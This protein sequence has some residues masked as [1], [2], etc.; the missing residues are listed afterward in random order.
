[1]TT[2]E[3]PQGLAALADTITRLT[4]GQVAEYVRLNPSQAD[5]VEAAIEHARGRSAAWAAHNHTPT[6]WAT[7]GELAKALDPSTVQTPALQL[8]DDVLVDVEAGRCPRTIISMPPQEGKTMRATIRGATW[9]LRRNMDLRMGIVSYEKD[10]AVRISY[11]IRNDITTFDG[12]DG[13]ID[14]GMRL[15]TDSKAAGWWNLAGHDGGV[16]AV[17]IGGGLTSRPLD[18]LW[19][20]DPVKDYRAVDS[21]VQSETAWN[22]WQ[23]VARPRLAPGAPVVLILTRWHELDLA[24][25]LLA[26]QASDEAAGLVNFDRWRVINIPAQADFDPNK[27]ESDILGRE[28]GEFMVSARGRTQEQWEATKAATAPRIWSALYQGK[29]TPDSGDVIKRAW[30]RRYMEAIWSQQPDGSYLVPDATEVLLSW[31]MTF[32]DNKSSDFVVGQVWVRKGAEVFLTD[33][34]HAR[35]SFTATLAAVKRM[36][37]R[38]PQATAKLVEDKANGTAVMDSLRKEVPGL[39]AVEPHGSKYARASAVSPFVEAGNVWFPSAEVALFDVDGLIE[40]AVAFPNA[41]HDDQVDALSQALARFFLRP[42]QGAAFVEAW[43]SQAAPQVAGGV[44][45]VAEVPVVVCSCRDKRWR[46]GVCMSCGQ[47][48]P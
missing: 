36:A 21:V 40:E 37:T 22:W 6:N 24:G 44:L 5:V 9:I 34:V 26:K 38:W 19:I 13:T 43:K 18:I 20:D 4:P 47:P 27:G 15:R 29:P 32:K 14:L 45:A 30:V 35:L 46:D 8:I 7:P 48:T 10:V 11:A 23:S 42:G 25:R 17:G 16:Y 31:D 33:Q 2:I 3:E 39:V 1:M 41:A 12:L 28:P